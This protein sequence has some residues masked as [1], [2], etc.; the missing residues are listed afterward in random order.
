L[1]IDLGASWFWPDTQ[2]LLT[3]LLTDLGLESYPQHDEGTALRLAEA[4]KKPEKIEV[5]GGVHGGAH[6]I[7]GGAQKTIDGLRGLLP[8]ERIHRGALLKS[9]SDGGDHVVLHFLQDGKKLVVKARRV[10][11]ALPPRLAEERIAFEP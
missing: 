7:A 1:A 4:D 8:A 11:L 10:V 5:A 9:L 3:A 6:K 2:P